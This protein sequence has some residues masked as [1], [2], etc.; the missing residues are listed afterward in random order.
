MKPGDLVIT[1]PAFR[2]GRTY[3]STGWVEGEVV[4]IVLDVP[5]EGVT[6]NATVLIC[7]EVTS[8]EATYLKVFDAG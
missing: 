4:G 3:T 6:L 1:R 5:R 7:G 8:I 2:N